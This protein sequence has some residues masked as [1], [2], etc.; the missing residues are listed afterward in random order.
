MFFPKINLSSKKSFFPKN[1]FFPQKFHSSPINLIF[2]LSLIFFHNNL[3]FPIFM[4][5]Q[6]EFITIFFP[7]KSI[8]PP[9]N[10][11]FL[12]DSNFSQKKIIFFPNKPFFLKKKKQFFSPKILP[13]L[14]YFYP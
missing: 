2:I 10:H 8:F 7:K 5:N 11:F 4:N 9:K 13:L 6:I 1:Q 14:M 3:A 12:K